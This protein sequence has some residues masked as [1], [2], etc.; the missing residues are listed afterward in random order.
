MVR[1]LVPVVRFLFRAMLPV[2]FLGGSLACAK[3]EVEPIEK[4]PAPDMSELIAAYEAPSGIL[5]ALVISDAMASAREALA[6]VESLAAESRLRELLEDAL[7]AFD[8]NGTRGMPADGPP[9]Q[10]LAFEGDGYLRV[11]R[12][13]DGFGPKPVPDKAANG[14]MDLT[15]GFTE[16]GVD[17]VVWGSFSQC[18]YL[19]ADAQVR[20]DSDT[21]AEGGGVRAYV[22]SNLQ[23]EQVGSE[24][25]LIDLDVT[26]SIGGKTQDV[27]LDFR[28]IPSD[29]SFELRVP[30]DSGD[31]IVRIAA[32]AVVGIRAK[33]GDFSCD[34]T[35]TTCTAD[36]A[37]P[38]PF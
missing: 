22:G 21:S 25:V 23:L 20:L 34:L 38:I 19:V 15:V 36:G 27:D 6:T 11:T 14:F 16:T 17:P 35:A 10:T 30:T 31:L 4:P 5:D 9:K 26:A 28:F 18:A 24:P 3:G 8:Q 37:D 33:N 32:Q 29:Q 1:A 2:S 13:C 7:A 12:I